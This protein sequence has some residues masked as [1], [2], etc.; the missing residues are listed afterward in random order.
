MPA[1]AVLGGLLLHLGLFAGFNS[2]LSWGGAQKTF[3]ADGC[4]YEQSVNTYTVSQCSGGGGIAAY[5]GDYAFYLGKPP[6]DTAQVDTSSWYTAWLDQYLSPEEGLTG[7]TMECGA[8]DRDF[9]VDICA[10]PQTVVDTVQTT[11][12]SEHRVKDGQDLVTVSPGDMNPLYQQIDTSC[13]VQTTLDFGGNTDTVTVSKQAEFN[14]DGTPFCL[15]T[16]DEL[17]DKITLRGFD[18]IKSVTVEYSFTTQFTETTTGPDGGSDD[19]TTEPVDDTDG[20]DGTGGD[21]ATGRELT[22][23]DRMVLGPVFDA[24]NWVTGLFG[25]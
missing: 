25:G 4:T 23:I 9:Y 20:S 8:S 15:V 1:W 10:D 11:F 22:G 18:F 12:T 7:Y 24:W 2:S 17:R 21:D 16:A 3:K 13:T 6:L 14:R 19:T 5:N